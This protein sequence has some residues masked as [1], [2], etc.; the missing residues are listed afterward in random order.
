MSF[1]GAA[2]PLVPA[3]L[4]F[5]LLVRGFRYGW[6]VLPPFSAGRIEHPFGFWTIQAVIAVLALLAAGLGAAGLI[7]WARISV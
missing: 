1:L 4:M 5:V 3:G 7:D 2:W 6:A